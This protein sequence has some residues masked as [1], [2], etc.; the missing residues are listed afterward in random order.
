MAHAEERQT[1]SHH[2]DEARY[3][4]QFIQSKLAS[5]ARPVPLSL[6][7]KRQSLQLACSASPGK[8]FLRPNPPPTTSCVFSCS[9][10][11][12]AGF[13]HKT[14]RMK[15]LT[16]ARSCQTTCISRRMAWTPGP[17]ARRPP[18]NRGSDKARHD[19]RCGWL[20]F[21]GAGVCNLACACTV[22]KCQLGLERTLSGVFF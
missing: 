18:F 8:R 12:A 16:A 20:R 15:S 19:A 10:F 9:L 1:V 17:S 11:L 7:A 14:A 13:W 6:L 3:S 22:C 21:C 4:A 5:T 2:R